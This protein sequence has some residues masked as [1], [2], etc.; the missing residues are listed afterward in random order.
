MTGYTTEGFTKEGKELP[1]EYLRHI[2]LLDTSQ[3]SISHPG[4]LHFFLQEQGWKCRKHVFL[5]GTESNL[6]KPI[7]KKR[8][9]GRLGEV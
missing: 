8:P 5:P 3:D 2:L 1:Q 4:K 7:I 6:Q 9:S